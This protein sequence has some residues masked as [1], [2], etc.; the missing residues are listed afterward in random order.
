[1]KSSKPMIYQSVQKNNSQVKLVLGIVLILKI[2]FKYFLKSK[3]VLYYNVNKYKHVGYFD[4]LNNIS[5][6]VTLT[7]LMD[8]PGNVNYAISVVGY[9]IF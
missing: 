7:Q 8:Y 6:H 3:H 2:L 1:M 5:E 4:I 9:W